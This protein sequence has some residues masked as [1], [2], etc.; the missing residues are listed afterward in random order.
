M[1]DNADISVPTHGPQAPAQLH[2]KVKLLQ[3]DNLFRFE[4][5]HFQIYNDTPTTESATFDFT[6]PVVTEHS[7]LQ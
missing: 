6:L 7:E 1:L 2:A 4:Y 3:I 5:A